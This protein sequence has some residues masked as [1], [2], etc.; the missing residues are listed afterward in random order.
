MKTKT[1]IILLLFFSCFLINGQNIQPERLR[2]SWVGNI[3]LPDSSKILVVMKFDIKENLIEGNLDVPAQSTTDIYIDS[4]R[5][6]KDSLIT[7]HSSTV[8]PGSFF[9]GLILPGDSVID[10]K[11]IQS[12]GSFPLRLR[13]TTDSFHPRTQKEQFKSGT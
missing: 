7:D 11:W 5:V 10:G 13:T 4:V 8:G 3:I 6:L 9:K 1:L 12:G 2:G